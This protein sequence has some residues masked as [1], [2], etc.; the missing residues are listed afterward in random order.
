RRQKQLL[1]GRG[2][3]DVRQL[4]GL[5]RIDDEVVVAR[6]HADDHAGVDA[7][8]GADE[9]HAALLQIEQR[10]GVALAGI[11]NDEHAVLTALQRSGVGAVLGEAVVQDAG[12]ARVGEE[13][14]AVADE[15][16]RRNHL[17]HAGA[18]GAGGA[19]LAQAAGAA[20]ELLDDHADE[21]VIDID[22][23]VFVR[24]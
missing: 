19:H 1:V 21:L 24:L 4:L 23:Q 7:L 16:A 9:Q 22:Q 17:L 6:V 14:I 3:A 10:V 5:R 20:T 15:A 8:A 12:A 18:A 11:L 13:L 2:G